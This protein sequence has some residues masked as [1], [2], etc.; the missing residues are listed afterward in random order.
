MIKKKIS[1]K[2][3]PEVKQDLVKEVGIEQIES[4]I[5]SKEAMHIELGIELEQLK[6]QLLELKTGF[7]KGDTIVD[8]EGCKGVVSHR[9]GFRWKYNKYKKDGNLSSVNSYMYK[10]ELCKKV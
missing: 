2:S 4:L 9:D 1:P 3:K 7:K 6:T 10:P 5:I 8:D